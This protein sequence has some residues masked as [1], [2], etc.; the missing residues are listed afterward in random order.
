MLDMNEKELPVHFILGMSEYATI[1]THPV[2]SRGARTTRGG[3]SK[4]FWTLLSPGVENDLTK[5]LRAKSSIE[6]YKGL[7]D[8]DIF[9]LADK[10]D[11]EDTIYQDFKEH[12]TQ[13]P[14][15]WYETCLLSKPNTEN[16]QTTKQDV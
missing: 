6:D 15:G 2:S 16:L 13:T 9:G 3:V 7:C 12:L 5:A 8:L 11:A 1:N 10:T 14:K 4:F